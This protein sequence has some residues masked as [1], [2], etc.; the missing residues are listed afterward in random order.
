MTGDKGRI[1][2]PPRCQLGENF[3]GNVNCH[4]NGNYYKPLCSYHMFIDFHCLCNVV[5]T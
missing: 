2:P 5:F 1:S 3:F 4:L